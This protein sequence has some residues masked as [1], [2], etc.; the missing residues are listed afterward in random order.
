MQSFISEAVVVAELLGAGYIAGSFVL[1]ARH[2]FNQASQWKSGSL[3][4]STPKSV[5]QTSIVQE[6]SATKRN[7]T[8]TER[9]RQQC[10]QA[11][12][13]WRN[14]HGKNKHLKKHEMIEALQQLERAK[15][16]VTPP[17]P[18]T[19]PVKQPVAVNQKAA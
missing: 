15:R 18:V 9:L 14:A 1:Y 13:K 17:K 8:P 11:G 5:P 10:Q 19:P 6:S 3:S 4:T 12:I 2:R 7:P 16:A